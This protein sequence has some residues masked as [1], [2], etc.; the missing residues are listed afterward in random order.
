MFTGIIEQIAKVVALKKEDSN[1]HFYLKSS[2]TKELKI[3]QSVAHNGVC[4]TVVNIKD[5]KKSKS[6]FRLFYLKTASVAAPTGTT[7]SV[8]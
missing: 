5:E 3:D 6:L 8:S 4:L 7:Q 2:I 1:A